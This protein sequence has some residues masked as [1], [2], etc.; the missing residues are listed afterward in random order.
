MAKS[1]ADKE[2]AAYM[3]EHG[4]RAPK[5]WNGHGADIRKD[6]D[7]VGTSWKGRYSSAY[8]RGMLGGI[9]AERLGL[10]AMPEGFTY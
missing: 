4:P 2:R 9:I 7:K 3:K 10:G 8:E 1:T 5:S 6:A